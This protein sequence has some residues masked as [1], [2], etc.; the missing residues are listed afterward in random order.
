MR[1]DNLKRHK[2]I[3]KSKCGEV[4]NLCSAHSYRICKKKGS[5]CAILQKHQKRCLRRAGVSLLMEE[6]VNMLEKKLNTL[7]NKLYGDFKSKSDTLK[8]LLD[9]REVVNSDV[10]IESES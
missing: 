2:E 7:L 9:D 5:S 8:K 4:K 3:C 10:V 1:S 6:R